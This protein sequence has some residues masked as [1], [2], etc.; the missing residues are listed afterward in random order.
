MEERKGAKK[1]FRT[2][3]TGDFWIFINDDET[4]EKTN[5]KRA[6]GGRE[7]NGKRNFGGHKAALYVDYRLL[8]PKK[9]AKKK[10]RWKNKNF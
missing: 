4:N 5:E 3:E 6:W 1:D 9:G 8:Q 10:I 7:L 2:I